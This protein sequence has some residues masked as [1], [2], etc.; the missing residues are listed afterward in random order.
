VLLLNANRVV[1]AERLVEYLWGEQPPPRAR[2]L[3]QGCVAQL[4]RSL[5]SQWDRVKR[6]DPA[7]VEL[8]D[9]YRYYAVFTDSRSC[10]NRPKPS[11][12]AT[13]SWLTADE[14]ATA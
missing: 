5:P 11:T 12:A 8:F 10:W 7:Q 3:L 2:S 9:R 14:R 4:R 1:S 13:P 6:A